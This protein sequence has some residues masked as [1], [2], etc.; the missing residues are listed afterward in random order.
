MNI[1]IHRGLEQ[2]GGCI[3]LNEE[4]M[5]GIRCNHFMWAEG[6]IEGSENNHA[7][8]VYGNHK[9]V[10]EIVLLTIAEQEGNNTLKRAY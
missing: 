2:I 10:L 5:F 7:I 4:S 3:T 9:D 6:W 8:L 1:T